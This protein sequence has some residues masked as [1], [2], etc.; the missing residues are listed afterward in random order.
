MN[1]YAAN[2]V[3]LLAVVATA[4]VSG[5]AG[6]LMDRLHPSTQPFLLRHR[7]GVD[8]DETTARYLVDVGDSA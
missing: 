4:L 1:D 5:L 8:R 3:F 7:R 6:L 2:I